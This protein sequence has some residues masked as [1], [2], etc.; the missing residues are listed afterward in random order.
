MQITH[1][2]IDPGVDVEAII[3]DNKKTLKKC[4]RSLNVELPS[5]MIFYPQYF[6]TIRFLIPVIFFSFHLFKK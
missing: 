2:D 6:V 4:I 5:S 1:M 3:T